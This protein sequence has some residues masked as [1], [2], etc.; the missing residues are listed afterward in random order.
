MC[1][2]TV[3]VP[4]FGVL[5]TLSNIYEGMFDKFLNT[6]LALMFT[7]Q[8]EQRTQIF[9]IHK[10]LTSFIS[11]VFYIATC[12]YKSLVRTYSHIWRKEI[13]FEHELDIDI[14]FTGTERVK[15]QFPIK[16]LSLLKISP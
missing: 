15:L 11:E 12:H 4:V 7:F 16:A 6:S 8:I 2:V 10:K 9:E 14:N 1:K 5:T 3:Q 13:P